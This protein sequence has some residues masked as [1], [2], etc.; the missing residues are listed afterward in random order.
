MAPVS[1]GSR[2]AAA[3]RAIMTRVSATQSTVLDQVMPRLSVAANHSVLWIGIAAGLAVRQDKWARRAALRGLASVVIA[4]TASNVIGKGLTRR[5]RPTSRVPPVRRLARAPRTTSFPSGHA[6]SAAAFATGVA[7][8]L[9]VLSVPV[10]V[11]AAAVGASRVVTGMHF[12]SD[13]A[14]GFATGIAAGTLTLRWWP[15]RQS[16][17]AE[18]RRPRHAAPAAPTG[19]GL[20][21][22][23]NSAAGTTSDALAASLRADLPDARIVVAGGG[24]LAAQMR[25]AASSATILGVAG[26]DGSVQLAAGMAVDRGLPLLVIPAGTFNHFATDLGLRSAAEA[27]AALRAGDSVLV[28]V[29]A[30]GQRSFVNT[31]STGIY[32]DLLRARQK[33]EGRLGKWPA[34]LVA[35]ARV[36]RTSRPVEIVVDG[37]PRKLWL[38][39]AGNCRYEPEGAAPSYRPDLVDGQLDLRLVDGQQPLARIRLMAAVAMGTLARSRVYRTWTARSVQLATPDGTPVLLSVDGEAMVAEPALTLRKRPERLLVYRMRA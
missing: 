14:V 31:A 32:V 39:F 30:A 10:G 1:L 22:V 28:D 33:L 9:P 34:V 7:L 12:P 2:I 27:L 5:H 3:D 18:A 35:L 21:L 4:S 37:R 20:V 23:M 8:E 29:A 11:L 19:E 38:L 25:E 24:D 36:L 17:P 13:V 6:A 26:G 15:L 16:E